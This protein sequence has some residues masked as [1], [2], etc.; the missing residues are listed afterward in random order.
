MSIYGIALGPST[1]V[2]APSGDLPT[3]L[4]GSSV[5]VNGAAAPI[6]YASTFRVDFQ[7]PFSL[8]AGSN[9]TVQAT[10]NGQSTSGL[11]VPVIATAPAIYTES[12]DGTGQVRAANQDGSMNSTTSPAAK[13]S[14]IVMYATGLGAA[15]PQIPAGTAPPSSPLSTVS[16]VTATIGGVN[17]PVSFAGLA[18]GLPGLYQ[19]NIQIPSTASSG[20]DELI[21]SVPNQSS[22]KGVLVQV[23]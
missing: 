2:A 16:G 14:T 6:A 17:A 19:L 12:V 13:G 8:T 3:S 18:P 21:V 15:N 7:A 10:Y 4:G 9:A 11:Q 5:T 1:A 22:Q 23:Q 20:A